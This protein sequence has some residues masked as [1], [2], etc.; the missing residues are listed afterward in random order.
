MVSG[1]GGSLRPA[2]QEALD[3]VCSGDVFIV[4]KLDRLARSVRD[5]LQI[6]QTLQDKSCDLQLLDQELA[7]P[8]PAS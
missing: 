5:L 6:T 8:T 2:L 1:R 4:T 7:T 3:Y